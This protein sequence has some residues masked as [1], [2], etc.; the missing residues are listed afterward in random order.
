MSQPTDHPKITVKMVLIILGATLLVAIGLV[1]TLLVTRQ[2]PETVANNNHER[3]LAENPAYDESELGIASLAEMYDVAPLE[4]A[5]PP[6]FTQAEGVPDKFIGGLIDKEVE[7]KLNEEMRAACQEFVSQNPDETSYYCRAT[8]S[9]GDVVP[10]SML[11]YDSAYNYEYKGANFRLDTGEKITF[12]DLWTTE[13][14]VAGIIAHAFHEDL[15]L[16]ISH[17]EVMGDEGCDSLLSKTEEDIEADTLSAVNEYLA[18]GDEVDFNFGVD[19]A[20]LTLGGRNFDIYFELYHENVAI[21][22]RFKSKTNLYETEPSLKAFVLTTGFD[23]VNGLVADNV[24]MEVSFPYEYRSDSSS[25]Q[26]AVRNKWKEYLDNIVK[27]ATAEYSKDKDN[28]YVVMAGYGAFT[29]HP[30]YSEELGA[31]SY[32]DKNA[33]IIN[34]HILVA[35]TSMDKYHEQG[36]LEVIAKDQRT[37]K[38]EVWFS[39]PDS[40]GIWDYNDYENDWE[41]LNG[42]RKTFTPPEPVV[43]DANGNLPAGYCEKYNTFVHDFVKKGTYK[44]QTTYTATGSTT[45][46]YQVKDDCTLVEVDE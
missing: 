17:C 22:K 21:Y 40:W 37:P 45:K 33:F 7:N 18:K 35:N 5:D 6:Y 26:N 44:D 36:G 14:N 1:T 32:E 41:W 30:S 2:K 25:A 3:T 20:T 24:F 23:Y 19:Y 34:S 29:N 13:A 11:S 4:Y 15:R 12:N 10:F 39:F 46:W 27:S 8:T 43:I 16:D 9:F 28:M 42:T 31:T 38:I